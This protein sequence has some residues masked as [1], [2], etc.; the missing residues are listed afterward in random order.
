LL[1]PPAVPGA[2][3]FFLVNSEFGYLDALYRLR[4]RGS[5]NYGKHERNLDGAH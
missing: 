4:L 2:A 1:D 5:R 3:T